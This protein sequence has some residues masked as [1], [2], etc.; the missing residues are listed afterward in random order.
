[1]VLCFQAADVEQTVNLPVTMVTSCLTVLTSWLIVTLT[2]AG[3]PTSVTV[4]PTSS[5]EAPPGTQLTLTCGENNGTSELRFWHTPFGDLQ[6]PSF[7]GDSVILQPDRSLLISNSSFLHSGFYY[8]LMQL[9][10]ETKLQPYQLQVHTSGRTGGPETGGPEKQQGVSDGL[11]AG[12]VAASVVITF[13]LGFS[14]GALTRTQVLRCFTAVTM[15]LKSPRRRQPDVPDHGPEVTMTTLPPMFD[16]QEMEIV[17]TTSSPPKKPQ[18][19]F[20]HKRDEETTEY[21][22]GCDHKQDKGSDEEMVEGSD[23]EKVEGSDEMVEGSDEEKAEG[24]DEEIEGSDETSGFYMVGGDRG[25]EAE[26]SDDKK[27]EAGQTAV[28]DSAEREAGKNQEVKHEAPAPRPG[29]RVIRLYNYD[30]DGHRYQHLPDPAPQEP[31][32]AP[33]LKQRSL[34]LTR[35]NAIMATASA[36]PLDRKETDGKATQHFHMEI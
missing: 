5:L 24:S 18:R 33:R 10:K 8:C 35:L 19:S 31:S 21:L 36:S 17:S 7:H 2:A 26:D 9:R 28:R 13:V 23:E 22:Q 32:P 25:S 27:D 12:A 20:R 11:F 30:E 4:E 15:K 1:M 6:G 3:G 16:N 14:V 29:R 34:S